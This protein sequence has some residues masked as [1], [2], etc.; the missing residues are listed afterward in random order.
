MGVYT[1]SLSQRQYFVAGKTTLAFILIETNA[2][3]DFYAIPG[4]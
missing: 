3:T 4:W 1:S 2:S